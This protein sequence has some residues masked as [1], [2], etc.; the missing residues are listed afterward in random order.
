[1]MNPVKLRT[2]LEEVLQ[3][4]ILS[5]WG[6]AVPSDF[7]P[8]VRGS[9]N[10]EFGDLSCQSAMKLA[11][12]L[13]QSPRSIAERIVEESGNQFQGVSGITV[14]GPG[15]I[16]FTLD[17][18][19]LAGVAYELATEGIAG[20]LPD[21]GSGRRVLVEY[22]SSNPTGPLTVGH[23]RQAVLG[24]AIARLLESLGWS[25]SREYYFN[26]GGRQMEL[27]GESLAARYSSE[28]GDQDIPEGGYRGGTGAGRTTGKT[29][30]N[31]RERGPW[32]PSNPT[33]L[34][35]ESSST[36]SSLKAISYRKP[37]PVLLKA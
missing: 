3:K 12:A 25:V 37:C 9:D 14:D 33:F 7:R 19:Y 20:M 32:K 24:E 18:D 21:S 6:N 13:R 11:G 5:I 28:G 4:S 1:M 22:V 35:W 2:E 34:C 17:I 10:L 8:E 16:N 31:S 29:S 30:S 23:C 26:D 36:A 15:Y 27:L